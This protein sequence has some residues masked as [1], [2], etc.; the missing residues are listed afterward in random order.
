MVEIKS[1]KALSEQQVSDRKFGTDENDAKPD[2][3]KE[4]LEEEI[5]P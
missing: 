4:D 3:Y 2:E 1:Q 5:S